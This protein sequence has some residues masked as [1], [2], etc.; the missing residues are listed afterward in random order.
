VSAGAIVETEDARHLNPAL[1]HASTEFARQVTSTSSRS[2]SSS[3]RTDRTR[4]S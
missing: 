2:A 1:V 4:S 3:A